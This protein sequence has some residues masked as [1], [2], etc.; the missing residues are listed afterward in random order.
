MFEEG[1]L[2]DG[3][4]GGQESGDEDGGE[5]GVALEEGEAVVGGEEVGDD[6]ELLGNC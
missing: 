2:V 5:D 6:G 1:V 4:D 3:E